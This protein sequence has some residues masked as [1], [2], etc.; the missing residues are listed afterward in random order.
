MVFFRQ[1]WEK[2]K[3]SAEKSHLNAL[4]FGFGSIIKL[5]L[6]VPSPTGPAGV[7]PA[8]VTHLC[9]VF[10]CPCRLLLKLTD[11]ECWGQLQYC[12]TAAIYMFAIK[13]P[14]IFDR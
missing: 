9:G 6:A 1:M 13:A 7:S 8:L 10:S 2:K 14:L 12:A 5:S 11:N 4:F 3:V